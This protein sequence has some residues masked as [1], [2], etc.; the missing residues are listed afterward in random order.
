ERA[1]NTPKGFTAEGSILAGQFDHLTAFAVDPNFLDAIA[2]AFQFHFDLTRTFAC[3][4][5]R[6]RSR[7]PGRS[8]KRG[9]VR[10]GGFGWLRQTGTQA[11]E[12]RNK[13]SGH[14]FKSPSVRSSSATRRFRSSVMSTSAIGW[15][16][17]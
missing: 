8:G 11:L 15:V 16:S 1:L 13:V 17:A 3:G 14:Y 12:Q 4:M 9:K 2:V 5:R 6:I 10:G 7:V